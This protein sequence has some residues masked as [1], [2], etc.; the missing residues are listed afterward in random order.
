MNLERFN[1]DNL[2]TEPSSSGKPFITINRKGYISFTKP[3]VNALLLREGTKLEFLK[4]ADAKSE[5]F[6]V[7][8]ANE[9]S[10][11]VTNKKNGAHCIQ[12]MPLAKKIF[13]DV[14]VAEDI[15]KISLRIGIEPLEHKGEKLYSI[16][17][18]SFK[19][20]IKK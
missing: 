6:I 13:A 8:S 3:V 2:K 18:N 20:F 17:T 15:N 4:N 10:F 19:E 7:I 9:N 1:R 5:W 12:S 16:L 14:P 11:S